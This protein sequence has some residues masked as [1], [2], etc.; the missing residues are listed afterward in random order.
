M[1]NRPLTSNNLISSTLA[2]SFLSFI[3][4]CSG[5]NQTPS[6]SVTADDVRSLI[7]DFELSG[8]AATGRELPDISDPVAQ[9]GMKLFFSKSLSGDMDTA[10]V[11][12]HHPMMGGGDNLSLPVGVEAEI[13]E[14][15]GPGRLH[16]SSGLHFDGGPT[17]PRN[18]PTTFNMGLWDKTIFHDGRIESLGKEPLKNGDDGAGIRTPD[19]PFASIDASAVNLT[20]AQ[21]RF[22]VTSIEEMRAGFAPDASNDDLRASLTARLVDQTIP[23]SW[24]AEFQTAFGSNASAEE[25]VTFDN[26][27]HALAEYE[28]SQ[29]F[30]NSPFKA[31]V[32][33]DDTAL[34]AAALR[35]ARLFY[36]DAPAGGA[37]CVG[38]HSGDFFTD[39]EFHVL[40]TPQI[41]RGKG[42][43]TTGDDDFGRFRETG[44]PADMYAF[45]TPTLLNV[46]VTGPWTHVG[47]Y[48]DLAQ[49]IAHHANPAEAIDAYD[50][51]LA[52][53]EPGIQRE[54]AE[55]NTRKALD[56]LEAL[57]GS[58]TSKLPV[59][60]LSNEEVE[61]LVAFMHAL[62]DP[63]VESRECMS[64]WIPD[65][66]DSGPDSLQLNAVNENN[67]LL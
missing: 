1:K 8:D 11:S 12:C 49:M 37:G 43:G 44:Q 36:A 65:N 5:D 64:A 2:A 28:R 21:A 13:P 19:T 20:Q 55:T 53:L 31:F 23:N 54:N 46:A 39:E 33:G 59:L 24:L 26:I 10:C 3:V 35:G 48:D 14:L 18:A 63:C 51:T 4:G 7:T 38:C 34:N 32:E 9:L 45:R 41:G 67:E 47:A 16:S 40:A 52:N 27:A 17:V 57:Q 30:T 60:E 66:T 56:A 15:L 42:D 61:D 29:V 50:F 58:G 22:P 6:A 62:T 25:L